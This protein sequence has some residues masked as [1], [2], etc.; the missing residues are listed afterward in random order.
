MTNAVSHALRL[1]ENGFRVTLIGGELKSSTEAIVGNDA[2]VNLQKFN[3][4]K[5]FFG[6]NAVSL[7]RGFTTPDINEALIK[8]TAIKHTK[9]PYILCDSSKFGQTC[10]VR[11]AEFGGAQIITDKLPDIS[12]KKY[13]N[14]LTAEE[15]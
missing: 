9:N 12:Y 3:F 1:A 13:E 8:E 5:G 2:Y 4:A 10:P 14:I 7:G 15:E 11:F 6:T